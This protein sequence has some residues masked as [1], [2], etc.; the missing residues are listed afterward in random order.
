M[1]FTHTQ[2]RE[3]FVVTCDELAIGFSRDDGGLRTLRRAG[4]PE[5]AGHGDAR[6]SLDV[7]LRDRGWLGERTLVRYLSHQVE[8][9]ADGVEIKVVIGLGPLIVEDRYV[10]TGTL[11]TRRLRVR[12][13]GE[14][15]VALVGVRLALPWIVVGPDARFEAPGNSVRPRVAAEVAADQRPG[16]LPRRFFAPGL[17]GGSA[18]ERAPIS[19]AGLLALHEPVGGETLLC[20]YGGGAEPALPEVSGNGAAV[21]VGHQVEIAARLRPDDAVEAG[22]QSVLLL[23]A[24][25]PEALAAPPPSCRASRRSAWTLSACCRS[26]S[27]ARRQNS[28]GTAR[29]TRAARTSWPTTSGSTGRSARPKTC[30]AWSPRRTATACG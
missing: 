2:T 23:R 3:R 30:A 22:T 7:A 14:D 29:P 1:A 27:A 18:F 9:H 26:G 25:W 24:D 19:A 11:V 10:V 28:P 15:E 16:V 12:N 5:L 4:G 13:I 6:P 20:W 8:E 17:R 21:T